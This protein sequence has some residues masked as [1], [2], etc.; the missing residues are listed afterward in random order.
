MVN[1]PLWT[2]D[3]DGPKW[4]IGFH[5]YKDSFPRTALEIMYEGG[6]K[7][8]VARALGVSYTTLQKWCNP[9]D[10]MYKPEF[11]DAMNA[12][13]GFAQGYMEAKGLAN[14]ENRRFNNGVWEFFMKR[15]FRED[16]GDETRPEQQGGIIISDS[17]AE[18]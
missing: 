12:G 2:D 6:T 15:R 16:Y 1:H 3:D 9:I 4:N 18:G 14:L 7:A 11:A 10:R 17:D 8:M 5:K 13:E